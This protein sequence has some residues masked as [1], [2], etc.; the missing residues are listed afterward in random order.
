MVCNVRNLLKDLLLTLEEFYTP[1]HSNTMKR[2]RLSHILEFLHF[3][4]NSSCSDT[5]DLAHVWLWEMIII[6]DTLSDACAEFY[7]SSEHLVAD[8]VII[9][10]KGWVIFK[11]YIPKKMLCHKNLQTSRYHSLYTWHESL[12][13]ERLTGWRRWTWIVYCQF[14]SDLFEDRN[15]TYKLLWH[16]KTQQ[17][18]NASWLRLQN[19]ETKK[20]WRRCKG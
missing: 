6:F 2:D 13:G 10:F 20:A 19:T 17:E 14:F 16:F 12:F 3:A 15:K 8:E 1:F 9:L 4:D 18:W 11:H 5:T 7:G